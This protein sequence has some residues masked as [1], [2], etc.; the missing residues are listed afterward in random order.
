MEVLNEGGPVKITPKILSIPPYISTSWSNIS[1]IHLRNHSQMVFSLKD[2][3]QVEIP[4]MAQG[5]IDEIFQA[6][7]NFSES[8]SFL[9]KSLFDN[10]LS[11]SIPI[12]ADGSTLDPLNAHMQHVDGRVAVL[13]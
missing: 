5:D 2:G 6:H 3:S 4:N 11:L 7:A 10:S 1:S 12:K 9:P 13:V 8:D